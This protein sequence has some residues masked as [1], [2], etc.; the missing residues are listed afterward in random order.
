MALE[1]TGAET[2][3]I[4]VL[5]HAADMCRAGLRKDPANISWNHML[6]RMQ[7]LLAAALA[8][9][10]QSEAALREAQS[11]LETVRRTRR[12]SDLAAQA[13]LARALTA[14]GTVHS[15]L[16]K[17]TP[18]VT[19]VAEWRTAAGFYRGAMDAWQQFPNRT[20]EPYLGF[21]RRS[22]AGLAEAER[23]LS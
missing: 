2:Q 19:R 12:P 15:I 13:Y 21:M 14:N 17:R 7:P 11:V 6:W 20:K 22:E 8:L 3:A 18:N 23:E 10:G 4:E 9:D 1:E 16:A 5:R